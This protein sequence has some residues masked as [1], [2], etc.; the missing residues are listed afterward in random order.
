MLYLC[1]LVAA[2]FASVRARRDLVLENLALR[3]QLAVY[4]RTR[5]TVARTRR[6]RASDAG[7]GRLVQPRAAVRGGRFDVGDE[8]GAE[9]W[10]AGAHPLQGSRK[11]GMRSPTSGTSRANALQLV[12]KKLQSSLAVEGELPE[13]G[14][15]A[16]GDDGD[17]LILAL[18]RRS[19]TASPSSA[20]RGAGRGPPTS[21]PSRVHSTPTAWV[22]SSRGCSAPSPTPPT[23]RASPS[24][25]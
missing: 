8:R 7:V 11:A 21:A 3:H 5:G 20:S 18:A 17:D 12:A 10:L 15:A 25:R 2:L 19:A 24:P 13:D 6:P 14:L 16:Y 1:L 4:T 22:T 9:C 23:P